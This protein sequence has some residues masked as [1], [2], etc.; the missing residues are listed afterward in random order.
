MPWLPP[1][2]DPFVI[3]G[4]VL[5]AGMG[6]GWVAQRVRLPGV[7]GQ[8]LAGVLMG[9]SVLALFDGAAVERLQPLT[10]FALALIG[11]TVG[12]HLNLR[13]L[14]NAGKRLIFLL[15]AESLVTPIFVLVAVRT[16][17]D[18]PP[19]FGSLLATL[20]ISTAPATI[21]ALVR[22]A[23]ARGV[24]VK[25]LIAAVAINNV[26]CIF[27]FEVARGAAK[28]G[29]ALELDLDGQLVP[30]LMHSAKELVAAIALGGGAALAAQLL[31]YR[32]L[33]A[34]RLAAVSV[35][36]ILLT[37]GLASELDL[38]PLL[39][40]LAL[41]AVQTNFS[42]SRERIADSVFANFEPVILCVFFTLAGMHL[43]L[44][45]I[46][47]VGV[48][49]LVFFAA[50][51]GGK[52]VAARIAMSLAGATERVRQGLGMA[53]V[54][55]AGVAIGLVILVQEDPAFASIRDLFAVSV[56]IS[57]TLNEIVGPILTRLALQRS[58]ETGRDRPHLVD[59]LEEENIVTGFRAADMEQ[60]IER[61][62]DLL[63]SSHQLQ[64]VDRA[65][66]LQSIRDREAQVSTCIGGGLAVPHGELPA[67]Y[68]MV[69]VMALSR[70]GLPFE[71]PDDAPV[72]CVVLLATPPG[73]HDRHLQVLAAL[74]RTFG[75]DP[76]LQEQLFNARSAAHAYEILYGEESEDFNYFL[77]E[78][79]EGRIQGGGR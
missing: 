7:T 77:G 76:A 39:A 49:A 5:V 22:E 53:L 45:D 48:I 75:G 10:H 19:F 72:H 52:L 59:F 47:T 32:V 62:T 74:A 50:R 18:T 11:V 69:G 27:L 42:R 30:I 68:P 6:L 61:L 51:I 29:I 13:R 57:V 44:A 73:E 4:V 26:T 60:A 41:G 20:A 1:T 36:S 43:H 14:R 70:I 79:D 17:T 35:I 23:R 54:P 9:P 58:G 38:S 78:P 12:A 66:L 55:Q 31:T 71:T 34:E 40:C 67:G 15:V 28:E 2:T 3:L 16:L 37:F 25:T 63:I 65:V 8:I 64:G 33:R 56:L 46:G 21:V 24:F